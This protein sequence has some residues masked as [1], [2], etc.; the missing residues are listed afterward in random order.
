MKQVLPLHV[1]PLRRT[2]SQLGTNRYR[3]LSTAGD[4]QIYTKFSPRGD[5]RVQSLTTDAWVVQADVPV[6]QKGQGGR[7]LPPCASAVHAISEVLLP[8]AVLE[9]IMS[10]GALKK[11]GP[12]SDRVHMMH[13]KGTTN[14]AARQ[15]RRMLLLQGHAC[16]PWHHLLWRVALTP[17][18]FPSLA[19]PLSAAA[20]HHGMASN[21]SDALN[22]TGPAPTFKA[23][24]APVV[25]LP[26]STT[27]TA[28]NV[29]AASSA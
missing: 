10:T 26:P 14:D 3:S 29:T 12:P 23:A 8:T 17:V 1:L 7:P 18:L 15:D 20:A 11:R 5:V 9:R 22:A 13:N 25:L 4:P 27:S 21:A 28:P 19:V 24:P 16:T 2:G 6:A